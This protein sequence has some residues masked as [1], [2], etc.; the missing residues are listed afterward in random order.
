MH[1]NNINVSIRLIA[2]IHL[3]SWLWET[4]FN[5]DFF[6]RNIISFNTTKSLFDNDLFS[7]DI[8]GFDLAKSLFNND[9]FSWDI[10]SFDLTKSLFNNNLLCGD[11]NSHNTNWPLRIIPWVV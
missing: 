9:F 1:F 2:F 10:I 11:I 7:W 4:L 8:V 5:D 6:S 3:S